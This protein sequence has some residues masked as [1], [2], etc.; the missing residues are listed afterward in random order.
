LADRHLALVIRRRADPGEA[1]LRAELGAGIAAEDRSEQ[2]SLR[3]PRR[4]VLA[5]ISIDLA[6]HAGSCC[7]FRSR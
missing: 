7:H 2:G 4:I 5:H 1:M 3:L 6:L